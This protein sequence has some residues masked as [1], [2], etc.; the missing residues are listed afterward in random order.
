MPYISDSNS[1][2]VSVSS[3]L[4]FLLLKIKSKKFFML[5]E[6]DLTLEIIKYP[7]KAKDMY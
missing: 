2:K 3:M 6:N 7:I 1:T 5:M 4:S